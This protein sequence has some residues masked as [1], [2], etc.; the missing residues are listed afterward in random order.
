MSVILWFFSVLCSIFMYDIHLPN[1]LPTRSPKR[2]DFVSSIVP[3][4]ECLTK[5]TTIEDKSNPTTGVDMAK[6]KEGS[7]ES[8]AVR[9]LKTSMLCHYL[10]SFFFSLPLFST[11]SSY[12]HCTVSLQFFRDLIQ[13]QL[14][15]HQ[16]NS[17]FFVLFFFY[18]KM[19]NTASFSKCEQ[20]IT[21]QIPMMNSIHWFNIT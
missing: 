5:L 8:E 9:L 7:V 13:I 11:P 12:S 1:S 20:F 21:C 17:V 10:I 16:P 14:L 2:Q 15:L 6:V 3:R 4:L 19:V 18:N